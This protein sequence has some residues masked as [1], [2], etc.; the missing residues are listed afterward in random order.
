VLLLSC[1]GAQPSQ[2]SETTQSFAEALKSAGAAA[3]YG[4][5][6][7]LD[8]RVALS[9]ADRFVESKARGASAMENLRRIDQEQGKIGATRMRLKVEP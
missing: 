9:I 8:V 6:E 1:E 3:V 4:A 5:E 2:P 7:K